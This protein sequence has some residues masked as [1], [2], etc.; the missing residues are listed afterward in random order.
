MQWSLGSLVEILGKELGNITA[1]EDNCW[2]YGS[3]I[4]LKDWTERLNV[5]AQP[6]D[7]FSDGVHPSKLTYQTW[8]KDLAN[9]IQEQEI[10]SPEG[11]K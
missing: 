9:Y 3:V 5:D 6:G 1:K 8:A 11:S 10:L 4:S 7:Y 2:Y